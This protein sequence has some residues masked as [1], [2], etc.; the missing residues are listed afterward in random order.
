M[1][2]CQFVNTNKIQ[3]KNSIQ[4]IK[5]VIDLENK[6][7]GDIVFVFCN[8]TYLLSKNIQFLNHNTLTDVITFDYCTKN[9]I[10]G[11]ILIS[12]DRVKENSTIFKVKFLNELDRVM[13]HGL[14]HLLGYKDK[15]KKDAEIMKSKENFYLSIK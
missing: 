9:K 2:D 4:W 5:K 8:D 3:L 6:I 14:L 13:V 12:L 11:D 1:I 15:T 10:T 7:L